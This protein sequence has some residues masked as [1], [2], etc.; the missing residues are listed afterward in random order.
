VAVVGED[1]VTMMFETDRG[2]AGNLVV[3]Q[4]SQGRKNRLWFEID[5]AGQSLSFDQENPETLLVGGRGRTEIVQRDATGFSAEAARLG[6]VPAGHPM[7][8]RDCFA[9]FVADVYR[10]VYE[11]A[12]Y[13]NAAKGRPSGLA[14]PPSHPTF[15]DAARTARITDAVLRSARTRTWI[16]V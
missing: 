11:N 10:A 5:G 7:G 3:S 4:I 13:E 2:A 8:Y 15:A 12:A 9:A 14:A 6:A 16:E 1:A